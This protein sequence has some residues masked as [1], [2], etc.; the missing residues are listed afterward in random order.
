MEKFECAREID[1]GDILLPVPRVMF[2][3]IIAQIKNVISRHDAFAGEDVNGV[4]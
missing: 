3:E 1:S 2:V 4:S